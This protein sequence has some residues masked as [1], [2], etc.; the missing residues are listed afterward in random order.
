MSELFPRLVWGSVYLLAKKAST[1]GAWRFYIQVAWYFY[2]H[3][4]RITSTC[5]STCTLT[6]N[7]ASTARMI[8]FVVYVIHIRAPFFERSIFYSRAILKS[9]RTVFVRLV[10]CAAFSIRE[11]FGKTRDLYSQAFLWA[12]RFLFARHS[13]KLAIS[14]RVSS[15]MR[16]V[17]CSRAIL[18]SSRSLFARFSLSAASCFFWVCPMD[19]INCSSLHLPVIVHG[20]ENISFQEDVLSYHH[21]S[22]P[23]RATQSATNSFEQ[24]ATNSFES[25][26]S[27]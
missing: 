6:T 7:L 3:F 16:S 18:K 15:S 10:L 11:P 20:G 26:F 25:V 13:E 19:H 5:T 12:Q 21:P 27:R 23:Q 4:W 2:I 9:S 1:S 8:N 22:N 14:I 17:F 24:S